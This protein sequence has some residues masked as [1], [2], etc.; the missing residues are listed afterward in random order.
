V[1]DDDFV[2][3]VAHRLIA[4]AG[5]PEA[6]M[7]MLDQIETGHG[8]AEFDEFMAESSIP[9]DLPLIAPGVR[10]NVTER[11]NTVFVNIVWSVEPGK[12]NV[13][14]WLDSLSAKRVV[15]PA[16]LSARFASILERHGF[17]YSKASDHWIR[18]PDPVGGWEPRS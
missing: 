10:G 13:G 8:S 15:C 1:N 3:N 12:G 2:I 6:A 11:G 5:S 7:K 17:T 4:F 9:T 18:E 14:R 16:V